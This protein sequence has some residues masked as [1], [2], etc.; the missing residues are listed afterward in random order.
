MNNNINL[1]KYYENY[2]MKETCIYVILSLV[3]NAFIIQGFYSFFILQYA[4]SPPP[5]GSGHTETPAHIG[6]AELRHSP[7]ARGWGSVTERQR[8]C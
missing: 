8:R 6:Q 4:P 2:I 5:S 3:L 7:T 1:I